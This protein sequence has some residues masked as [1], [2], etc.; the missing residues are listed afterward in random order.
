VGKQRTS[1]IEGGGGGTRKRQKTERITSHE[2]TGF[3]TRSC[4]KGLK[5]QKKRYREAKGGGRPKDIFYRKHG[6]S[7]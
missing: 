5:V 2:T 3:K 7:V 6:G 4:G 1:K